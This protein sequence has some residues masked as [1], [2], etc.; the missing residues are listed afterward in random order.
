L[1]VEKRVDLLLEVARLPGVALTIVGDGAL[2]EELEMRFAGTGTHFTGYLFGDDLPQAYASAD[3]FVFTG[4]AETFGQVVQEAM[5]SGLPS[6]V[7]NQGGVA[8]L[9]LEGET[10]FTCPDDPAAF[11][12]AVCRLRD[13]PGLRASMAARAY[14]I[15]AQRPWETIMAQLEQHY[16][17]AVLLN[18]RLNRVFSPVG[19]PALLHR[20]H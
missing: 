3:V 18:D 14:E 15:A 6:V 8:D 12:A 11:A 4:A 16:A 13:E 19:L 10:G 17:E 7:I 9:V 2:R 5:A 20:N 1:A